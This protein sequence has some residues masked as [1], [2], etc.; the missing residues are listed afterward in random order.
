MD[1][2]PNIASMIKIG[3]NRVGHQIITFTDPENALNF[4]RN[5]PWQFDLVVSDISMPKIS[6]PRS[7]AR[8]EE[9]AS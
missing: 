1:D 3:V 8:G 5:D 7:A 4:Y 2:D 6:G 9:H